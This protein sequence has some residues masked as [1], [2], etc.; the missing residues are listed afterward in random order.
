M[1]LIAPS[2]FVQGR[3]PRRGGTGPL[4]HPVEAAPKAFGAAIARISRATRLRQASASQ[5]R[6]PLQVLT[7]KSA[8]ARRELARFTRTESLITI[9]KGAA[10]ELDGASASV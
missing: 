10:A 6:L 8:P 5:T 9:S 7:R 2:R 3:R 1:K 4:K